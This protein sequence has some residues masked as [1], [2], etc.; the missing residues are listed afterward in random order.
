MKLPEVIRNIGIAFVLATV[1]VG[2]AWMLLP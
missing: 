2:L 1:L